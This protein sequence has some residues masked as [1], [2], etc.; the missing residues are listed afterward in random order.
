MPRRPLILLLIVLLVAGLTLSAPLGD[1]TGTATKP[2]Y[3]HEALNA[4]LAVM[5]ESHVDTEQSLIRLQGVANAGTEWSTRL[6]KFRASIA[7]NVRFEVDVFVVNPRPGVAGLCERMFD[8]LRNARVSFRPSGTQLRTASMPTLDRL[9]EFA[10]DCRQFEIVITG[11]SDGT[12]NEANNRTLS[13]A[14]AQAVADYL[15]RRGAQADRLLVRGAGSEQPI[16]DD[17]TPQ[18]RALNRRIEFELR[19]AP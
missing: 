12:G 4:L 1:A 9:A 8:K 10:R 15:V 13:R 18:G 14:R 6:A 7:D 3:S 17:A 11:H 19:Q 5:R 16:A 2:S